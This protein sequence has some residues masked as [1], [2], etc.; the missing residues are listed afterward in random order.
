MLAFQHQKFCD[1]V[2]G[3]SAGPYAKT[4]NHLARGGI[5]FQRLLRNPTLAIE[6][7]AELQGCEVVDSLDDLQSGCEPHCF[8]WAKEILDT[9]ELVALW[10]ET[11][12]RLLLSGWRVYN[13]A[14]HLRIR[15][16]PALMQIAQQR[17]VPVI[18]TTQNDPFEGLTYYSE[19][20]KR[21][22][23]LCVVG[24]SM[25]AGKFTAQI[26][27]RGLFDAQHFATEP[28]GL[29]CGAEAM[30]VHQSIR[31]YDVCPAIDAHLM[32]IEKE[33]G[34]TWTVIGSQTGATVQQRKRFGGHA[35]GI[36]SIAVVQACQ[37]DVLVLATQPVEIGVLQKELALLRC[38]SDASVAFITVNSS[39]AT[40]E[41]VVEFS[42]EVERNLGIRCIDVLGDA[43]KLAEAVSKL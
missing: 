20:R 36:A 10:H 3:Y 26:A 1:G 35:G 16:D 41:R 7:L 30:L 6:P 21:A 19:S 29:F 11:M 9:P 22:K 15:D 2:Q 24:T 32:H 43:A 12:R 8:I 4:V 37:P 13:M 28:S 42:R 25:R 33:H 23:R 31:L 5:R 14:R 18:D 17:N 40:A 27:L 38:L 34:K 39:V